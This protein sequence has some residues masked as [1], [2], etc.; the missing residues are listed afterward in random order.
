[1]RCQLAA[2]QFGITA[3]Y[4]YMETLTKKSVD[5]QMP[6]FYILYFIEQKMCELSIYLVK[7]F[8]DGVHIVDIGF[9]KAVVVEVYIRI[10]HFR[11]LECID[12]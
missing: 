9:C 4:D 3:G 7:Y 1:M 10:L 5:E 6:T 8:K 12:A 11:I 2:K